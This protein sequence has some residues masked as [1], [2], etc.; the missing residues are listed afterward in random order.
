MLGV[1]AGAC[2]GAQGAV[3]PWLSHTPSILPLPPASHES[4]PE[5]AHA[6]PWYEGRRKAGRRAGWS[7]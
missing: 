7:G 6:G 2:P 4:S 5:L 3:G 1:A